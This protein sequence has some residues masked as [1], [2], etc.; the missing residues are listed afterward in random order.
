MA[1]MQVGTDDTIYA[2]DASTGAL[3]WS[4]RTAGDI[5]SSP[6]V[7]NGVVYFG[8]GDTNVYALNATT[9]AL[10]WKHATAGSIMSSA[11]VAYGSVYIASGDGNVYALNAAT[12]AVDWSTAVGGGQPFVARRGERARIHRV[13]R[14]RAL[15]PEEVRFTL[16]G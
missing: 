10:K 12:G 14:R 7:A 3:K 11:A 13:R 9:G 15:T 1:V 5:Q 16:G 6:A 8:S 2:L 4:Y